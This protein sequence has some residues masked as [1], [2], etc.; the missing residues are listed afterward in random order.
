MAA[1]QKY[2]YEQKK[3]IKMIEQVWQRAGKGLNNEVNLELQ[4]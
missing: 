2:M 4:C 1:W 3:F